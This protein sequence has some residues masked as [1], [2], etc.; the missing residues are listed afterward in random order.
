[1]CSY[2]STPCANF[3]ETTQLSATSPEGLSGGL[4]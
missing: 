3:M 2:K 4:G 1:M